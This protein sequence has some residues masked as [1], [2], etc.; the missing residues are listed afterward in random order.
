LE[1]SLIV[2]KVESLGFVK[3]AETSQISVGQKHERVFYD[4]SPQLF[5]CSLRSELAAIKVIFC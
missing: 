4:Q 3:V 2:I 1:F 5:N